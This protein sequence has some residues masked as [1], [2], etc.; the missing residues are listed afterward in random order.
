[1]IPED[2][3]NFSLDKCKRLIKEYQ[4]NKD[5]YTRDLLLAKFDKYLG[6]LI[7]GL[8]KRYSYL[9]EEKPQGLYHTAIL[10]FYKALNVFNCDLPSNMIFFVIRAYVRSELHMVYAYKT[11]EITVP[12]LI[13]Q[14]EDLDFQQQDR[15]TD[16]FRLECTVRLLIES[17]VLTPVERD[18][19]RGMYCDGLPRKALAK[20]F[21]YSERNARSYLAKALK[22]LKVLLIKTGELPRKKKD[23][24]KSTENNK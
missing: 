23:G 18:L 5:V 20:K 3:V 10:G 16:E 14:Y 8:R 12:D 21:G 4:Q 22:K 15:K 17:P 24:N 1:M 9:K 7:Y 6:Y 19:L 13:V 11:R 2:Y